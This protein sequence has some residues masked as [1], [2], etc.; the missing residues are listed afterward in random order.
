MFE[1]EA[2]SYLKISQ[3]SKFQRRGRGGQRNFFRQNNDRWR[4]QTEKENRES[5]KQESDVLGVSLPLIVYK[6]CIF[7]YTLFLLLV[8][9]T[10]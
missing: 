5:A 10:H 3:F 8:K 6:K 1:S 2:F 9:F 4:I 7:S